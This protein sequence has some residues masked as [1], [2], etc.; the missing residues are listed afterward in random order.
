MPA[1]VPSMDKAAIE[2]LTTAV[3]SIKEFI[4][5]TTGALS[6]VR[7]AS[8]NNVRVFKSIMSALQTMEISM[9]NSTV[10]TNM[11][12]IISGFNSNL[13]DTIYVITKSEKAEEIRKAFPECHVFKSISDLVGLDV[14][15]GEVVS[16]L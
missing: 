7:N 3:T 5:H 13:G 16:N 1:P 2:A 14:K 12:T 10:D 15:T 11:K 9:A 6:S 8:D 4:E